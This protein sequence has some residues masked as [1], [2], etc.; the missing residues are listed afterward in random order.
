M[1]SILV[2]MVSVVTNVSTSSSMWLTRAGIQLE[3]SVII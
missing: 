2:Q 3:A 1:F